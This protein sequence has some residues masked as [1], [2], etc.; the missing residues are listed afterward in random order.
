METCTSCR[1]VLS[2]RLYKGTCILDGVEQAAASRLRRAG[3]GVQSTAALSIALSGSLVTPRGC[4]YGPAQPGP[5]IMCIVCIENI[6]GWL[7]GVI[8]IINTSTGYSDNT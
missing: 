8:I 7:A 1:V 2:S 6:N 4:S 3:C 5:I